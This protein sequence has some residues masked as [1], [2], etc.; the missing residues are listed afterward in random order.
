MAAVLK[1][2][3]PIT[4][5]KFSTCFRS[6]FGSGVSQVL[7]KKWLLRLGEFPGVSLELVAAKAGKKKFFD[8]DKSLVLYAP[9]ACSQNLVSRSPEP[10]ADSSAAC[11]SGEIMQSSLPA[12]NEDVN[13]GIQAAEKTKDAGSN[14]EGKANSY[15][16]DLE[17]SLLPPQAGHIGTQNPGSNVS[18]LNATA[19]MSPKAKANVDM[20][21]TL[22]LA[23]PEELEAMITALPRERSTRFSPLKQQSGKLLCFITMRSLTLFQLLSSLI[24]L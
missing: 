11:G 8:V 19:D 1:Q 20:N 14:C 17:K 10:A 16:M 22:E 18:T 4:G 12:C 5:I 23:D 3:S 2:Q 13:R 6:L 21:A 7:G 15:Q 9:S 24:V